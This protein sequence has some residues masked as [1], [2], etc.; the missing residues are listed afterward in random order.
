MATMAAP[1]RPANGTATPG[2]QPST[3]AP[4]P[5]GATSTAPGGATNT[6]ATNPMQ[7]YAL[8]ITADVSGSPAALGRFLDQLQ[9]VQPRAVLITQLTEKAATSAQNGHAVGG[10][11]S[12][13]LS[14]QA[15]VAPASPNESAALAQASGR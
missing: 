9:R 8:P 13:T 12:L 1:A 15:F 3:S 7:I 14:M 6:G 4:A 10:S 2:A 5:G 11:T